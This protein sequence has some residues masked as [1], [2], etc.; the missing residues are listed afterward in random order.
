MVINI[1]VFK[2]D[3]LLQRDIEVSAR[4]LM[5]KGTDPK[6]S[7]KLATRHTSVV[8]YSQI[9]NTDPQYDKD[10]NAIKIAK[11]IVGNHRFKVTTKNN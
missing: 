10:I 7:Y 3:L 2:D 4:A 5:N 8:R 1:T 9:I 6:R 11:D